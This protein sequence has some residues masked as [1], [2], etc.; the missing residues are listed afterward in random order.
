MEKNMTPQEALKKAIHIVGSQSRLA[1]EIG[2]GVR[3]AHIYYWL[4]Q[5][6]AVPAEHC[7]TIEH[8]VKRAVRCEQLNPHV[9]WWVLRHQS[10]LLPT[11]PGTEP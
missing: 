5:A 4:T 1:R 6:V 3:Q 10:P 2:G 9:D 7:P 8:I 11:S